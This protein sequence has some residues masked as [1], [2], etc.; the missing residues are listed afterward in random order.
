MSIR[1]RFTLLY[2]LILALTLTIFWMFFGLTILNELV[3]SNNLQQ[4][5]CDQHIP[6]F[7]RAGFQR[8]LAGDLENCAAQQRGE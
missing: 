2:T 1:L 5:G 6:Y 4:R 7:H 3:P 8:G